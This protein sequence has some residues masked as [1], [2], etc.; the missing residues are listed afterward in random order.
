MN[1]NCQFANTSNK[2]GAVMV[3]GG[4]ISGMQSALDLANSGFK[5]YLVE[6]KSSIGGRMAQLDKTF[7]TND[8]STCLIS[9]KLIE[10][11]KHLNIEII[12]NASVRSVDGEEGNMTV[13]VYEKPRFVDVTK[14]TSCDECAKVCPV[15]VKSDFEGELVTHR[16]TCRRYPQAIPAAYSIIKRGTSPCKAACPAHISVQGYVALIAEGRFKE[17][18]DLIREEV[19]FPGALGRVCTHPCE[20]KCTRGQVDEAVSICQLKRYVTDEIMVKGKDTPPVVKESRNKKVAIVGSG[21]AG[22][23]AAYYL[24]LWGYQPTVFEA[25]PVAGGMMVVGIP[26]YRLPR[27]V[28]KAEIDFIKS[29]GVEIKTNTPVGGS[30]K[31]NDLAA[32]G[33]EATYVAVGAHRDNKL[34]IEGEDLKGVISGVGLLRD[35]SLGKPGGLGQK[36]AVVGGGNVA[37]DAARTALRLGAKE[38]TIVYRR[39][40]QE[41]P[42]SAEEIAEAEEEGIKLRYLTAPNK[43]V[44]KDGKVVALE[45]LRME[46][47]EPDESGRRRPV[48]VK[49]SGFKLEVDTIIPAI[50]QAPDLSFLDGGSKIETARGGVI[51]ADPLTFETGMGGVFAGGDAVLGPATV[52]Q[53][54]AQGKQAAISI[55]RYLRGEDLRAGREREFPEVEVPVEGVERLPRKRPATTPVEER[56]KDFREVVLGYPM[57]DARAE[58]ERCLSCGI[59]SECYRCV[60]ACGPKAID[61]SMKGAEREIQVGSVILSPGFEPFD[62]SH[63]KGEYRHGIAPNVV[64]SLQFE[65]I[66]SASGPYQG[67]VQRPS[68]GKHPVKVAWIQCVGSRDE[69]CGRDY[70]SSVCCMYATKQTIIAKEHDAHIQPTVFYNDMR[71]FGKGFERYYESAK[72]K[73]GVRYIRGLPSDVKELQRTKNLL[74]EY[75]GDDGK[76]VRE[77]FDMVVLSV[78]LTPSSSTRELGERLGVK[79]NRFGFCESEGL[80]PNVSSRPGIYVGGAFESPMDIPESVMSGSSAACLA[81]R[82]IAEARGSLVTARQYPPEIDVTNE[83]PRIGVFI[84]RC[85]TNIARVVNVP[86]VARYA[87]TLPYVAH[88]EENLYTCS[89]DCQRK[90]IETIKEKKL[91]RV[92]VASCTPRTHEPLFQETLREAGLNK[93]LFEMANIRDQCSWVHATHPDEATYKSKDLVRMAVARAANL[94]PLYDSTAPVKRTGLVIGGGLAGMTAALELATQGYE[95]VLVERENEL[96]GNLRHLYSTLN[97]SDPQALLASLLKRVEQTSKIKVYK[98]AQVKD[99]SGHI[100]DYK[101]L[102][103]TPAGEVMVEHGVVIVATGGTEYK[104]TEYLADQS[105]RVFTQVELEEKLARGNGD[106]KALKSVVMVQCVGSREKDHMYC[107]RVCCGQAIKN[108]LKLKENNPD[109]EVYVLYRDIRAYGMKELKYREAREKG[110]VFVRFDVE[111]RPEVTVESGKLKVKV[112]DSVLGSNIL[113]DPDILVLSAAIRPQLDAKEFATR[114]KLP[115]TQDGFL[116]EAHM[117]LRPLDF[118][119]DG[120]YLCGLAHSPKTIEETI[121]QARGAV[122]R[123]LTILSQPFLM[124]GGVISVVDPDKCVACLTCVRSCPFRV[125]LINEKGVAYIEPAA[126]Q[127][128]G[129]CTAACPRKAIT[130]RHY[131]DTQ[132]V[133]KTAVLCSA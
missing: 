31:L 5:V 117:K 57:E 84:C 26:A 77:E 64:T 98:S 54:I 133:S 34:G 86:G 72:E 35:A 96:G 41:M 74:L 90:L 29:A 125:P 62:P 114:L 113:L 131:S 78:G 104:P 119:N 22:L 110:V 51:K 115:L 10:V 47:G 122:S 71:A 13:K 28:L 94:Q 80:N 61:H 50:G 19:P 12:T 123:S 53:A 58:A 120:M 103:S 17:A 91:N 25:L 6:E 60:A 65:R 67:T 14:C 93:Y 33:Y 56:I 82:A 85:G 126:C 127:G 124:V 99:F 101:T 37:I 105:D 43:L 18:L 7:P 36:V 108:A 48:P 83:E 3:V 32:Q 97:G 38:V 40:R 45:C 16:A 129:I 30:L 20:V 2:V 24:A 107:S 46:L 23:S 59:C 4:G 88:A 68:D 100:G 121:M 79:L 55:D 27:D 21:P 1:D 63:L 8:C 70:C 109:T 69:T 49:G 75:T 89:T 81:S 73:Y 15:K 116:M 128:C 52:I 112:F 66:L 132:V 111:K 39:S 76:K 42:A 106:V 92:V 118:V 95:A 11:S 130:L 87:A 102:I 9:P 44:G